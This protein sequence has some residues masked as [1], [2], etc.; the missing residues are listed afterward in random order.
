[1]HSTARHKCSCIL[2]AEPG[3]TSRQG[4]GGG[5][6]E[7]RGVQVG[8]L[9]PDGVQGVCVTCLCWLRGIGGCFCW[10]DPAG[11]SAAGGGEV[12]CCAVEGEGGGALRRRECPWRVGSS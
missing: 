1:M 8:A 10:G 3:L 4:G 7:I 2:Y 9:R 12:C 11:G 6:V 5:D